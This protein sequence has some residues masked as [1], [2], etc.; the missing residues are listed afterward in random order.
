[1][2]WMKKNIMLSFIILIISIATPLFIWNLVSANIS[3]S[4]ETNRFT[5]LGGW[6]SFLGTLLVGIIAIIQTSIYDRKSTETNNST[7]QLTAQIKDYVWKLNLPIL[8]INKEM[9]VIEYRQSVE[10]PHK[11]LESF[12]HK[13]E[14]NCI[15]F[16]LCKESDNRLMDCQSFYYK[17]IECTITNTSNNI[18]SNIEI[19]E[20]Q[21][22]EKNQDISY[23]INI[24]RYTQG[25]LNPQDSKQVIFR[26][27]SCKKA[28]NTFNDNTLMLSFTLQITD[29][30]GEL[31]KRTF[32]VY[33]SSMQKYPD[34]RKGKPSNIFYPSVKPTK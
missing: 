4:P 17:D 20:F 5:A 29:I 16:Y 24:R 26:I 13:G 23:P 33:A 11:A 18:I 1:M 22:R 28:N 27:F 6:V 31:S 21:K 8:V 3:S 34:C 30:N 10:L 19:L 7:A 14:S 15:I 32:Q 12:I 9:D 25:Y 2:K